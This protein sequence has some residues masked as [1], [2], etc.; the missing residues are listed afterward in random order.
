M[1][2]AF[3]RGFMVGS[4]DERAEVSDSRLRVRDVRQNPY[5]TGAAQRGWWSRGF[6]LGE[7][8]A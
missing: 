4:D 6:A 1:R 5:P 2:R 7:K 8:E 3:F